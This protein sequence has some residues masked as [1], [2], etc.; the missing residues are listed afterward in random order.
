MKPD[1][2]KVFVISMI[3]QTRKAGRHLVQETVSEMR[4]IVKK[5][6]QAAK[7]ATIR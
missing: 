3:K 5:V 7:K 2:G 6:K 1:S 4:P